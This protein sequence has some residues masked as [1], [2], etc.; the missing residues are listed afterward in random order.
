M[1]E[2]LK[3]IAFL[4]TPFY[5]SSEINMAEFLLAQAKENG[6]HNIQAQ[7][8]AEMQPDCSNTARLITKFQQVY[9][10]S[11][12]NDRVMVKCFYEMTTTNLARIFSNKQPKVRIPMRLRLPT[13][14]NLIQWGILPMSVT[15]L[16]LKANPAENIGLMKD[17]FNMN[18][19]VPKCPDFA[20]VCQE[21]DILVKHA[22]EGA[23]SCRLSSRT[24]QQ[25]STF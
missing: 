18:K 8:L 25:R 12:P 20:R 23:G 13:D 6:C 2:A 7:I 24:Q 3:G 22:V 17:H 15:C 10:D 11:S 5:P 4:A 1:A 14:A 21:I 19:F 16:N 9:K